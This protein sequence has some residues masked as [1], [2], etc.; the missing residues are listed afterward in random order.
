M[1]KL[2]TVKRAVRVSTPQRTQTLGEHRGLA[3]QLFKHFCRTSQ[4]IAALTNGDVDDKLVDFDVAH[5]VV[6]TFG[7]QNE[8]TPARNFAMVMLGGF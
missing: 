2:R 6:S 3:S 5:G 1:P 4:T 7:L 8:H